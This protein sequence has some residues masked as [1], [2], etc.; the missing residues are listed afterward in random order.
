MPTI[1]N[2]FNFTWYNFLLKLE[3]RV[4]VYLK[5]EPIIKEDKSIHIQSFFVVVQ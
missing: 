5:H 3:Y 4:V 2:K 1:L